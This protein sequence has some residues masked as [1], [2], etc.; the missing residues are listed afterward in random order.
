MTHE[1]HAIHDEITTT[2][3]A[4]ANINNINIWEA[5]REV[6]A[7]K[8]NTSAPPQISRGGALVKR[9]LRGTG[10]APNTGPFSIFI[11]DTDVDKLHTSS[12]KHAVKRIMGIRSFMT[13]REFEFQAKNLYKCCLKGV[14]D[15]HELHERR[16]IG[17]AIIDD[18]ILRVDPN[19]ITVRHVI[20][21]IWS[22]MSC[23]H[24]FQLR[25]RTGTGGIVH[26]TRR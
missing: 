7:A 16:I 13:K 19:Y 5:R 1:S 3:D 4:I 2:A 11:S 26:Y 8:N 23:I 17:M 15:M 21:L 12:I 22:I 18:M 25:L 9:L 24:H 14:R 20:H 6:L 10:P